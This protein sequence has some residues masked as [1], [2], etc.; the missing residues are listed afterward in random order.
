MRKETW[1]TDVA[2]EERRGTQTWREKRDVAHRRGRRERRGIQTWREK[3]DVAHRRGVRRET[4]PTD[5]HPGVE[6]F[7]DE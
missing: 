7:S 4:W 6:V 2:S 1:P 5:G 3:R